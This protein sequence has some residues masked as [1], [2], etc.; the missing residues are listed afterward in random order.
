MEKRWRILA[1]AVV[2]IFCVLSCAGSAFGVIAPEKLK[3]IPL[4]EGSTVKQA[5]DMTNNAMLSATVKAKVGAIAEFYRNAMS[6]KGWK[7]VFQAEQQDIKIIQFQKDKQLLQ[8]T[9]QP[10]K[11]GATTTYTLTMTSQ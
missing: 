7:T 8:V 9:I 6:A 11:D 4:Y 10:E 1:Y 5:I 2:S 3:E